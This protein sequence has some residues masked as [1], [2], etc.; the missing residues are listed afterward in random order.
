MKM[1]S[2]NQWL[3]V[4]GPDPLDLLPLHLNLESEE[5]SLD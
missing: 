4:A 1:L 3:A 2:T 5:V